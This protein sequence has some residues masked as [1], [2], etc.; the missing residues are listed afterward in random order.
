M[1]NE[2]CINYVMNGYYDTIPDRFI[3]NENEF[4][5]FA[6]FMCKRYNGIKQ[7][8]QESTPENEEREYDNYKAQEVKE[9]KELQE[10]PIMEQELPIMEQEVPKMEEEV[11]KMEVDNTLEENKKLERQQLLKQLEEADAREYGLQK[12]KSLQ[13]DEDEE[14]EIFQYM[15]NL[16][17][18]A[19]QEIDADAIEAEHNE[20]QQ[21]GDKQSDDKTLSV[22]E[23]VK[24]LLNNPIPET[25]I[26]TIEQYKIPLLIFNL[27][28]V[29]KYAI[30]N[31][32]MEIFKHVNKIGVN[33]PEEYKKMNKSVIVSLLKDISENINKYCPD[34]E[35]FLIQLETINEDVK[36]M[37]LIYDEIFEK[38]ENIDFFSYEFKGKL[39]DPKRS[40]IQE[41]MNL[42]E[43]SN[44]LSQGEVGLAKH[45]IT[46]RIEDILQLLETQDKSD[47][48]PKAAAAPKGSIEIPIVP[49]VFNIYKFF[50]NFLKYISYK[51]LLLNP[52]YDTIIQAISIFFT[53]A[54]FLMEEPGRKTLLS[55][56]YHRNRPQYKYFIEH[57]QNM[58]YYI[59][60]FSLVEFIG[61]QSDDMI[62]NSNSKTIQ[63]VI[64]YI[65]SNIV[66][67]GITSELFQRET[68][69]TI[70]ALQKYD[71]NIKKQFYKNKDF[72]DFQVS[73][74][75][76]LLLQLVEYMFPEEPNLSDKLFIDYSN[77]L[78]Q[79]KFPFLSIGNTDSIIIFDK[80]STKKYT[81]LNYVFAKCTPN[82]IINT[83]FVKMSY[84]L[85][86]D[87]EA[88]I[89][90]N[91]NNI[92]IDTFFTDV[93]NI[94]S[95][96]KPLI[97][98][99]KTKFFTYLLKFGNGVVEPSGKPFDAT[100][101][102]SMCYYNYYDTF[103][104]KL[105]NTT[106]TANAETI[107]LIDVL[108]LIMSILNNN[109]IIIIGW[110]G[111]WLSKIIEAFN[112]GNIQTKYN[113]LAELPKDYDWKFFVMPGGVF[114]TTI[115]EDR[116]FFFTFI[117]LIFRYLLTLL[118]QLYT[119]NTE[120]NVSREEITILIKDLQIIL[121]TQG[122]DEVSRQHGLPFPENLSAWTANLLILLQTRFGNFE[123]KIKL[124]PFD[125]VFFNYV[126]FA[127][128]YSHYL[129]I[130]IL[131]NPE[132]F[133]ILFD[134]IPILGTSSAESTI[135]IPS[136]YYYILNVRGFIIDI[137]MMVLDILQFTNRQ[138]KIKKDI[139]RYFE[140]LIV[141]LNEYLNKLENPQVDEAKLQIIS[142]IDIFLKE[143][144]VQN[145]DDLVN[146]NKQF[147]NPNDFIQ[148][149]KIYDI[150]K[151]EYNDADFVELRTKMKAL[152]SA[153]F[154][155]ETL[156]NLHTEVNKFDI[157][158]IIQC[159]GTTDGKNLN[160]QFSSL[161]PPFRFI[162]PDLTQKPN[163]IPI[164]DTCKQ[165]ISII[166][167]NYNEICSIIKNGDETISIENKQTLENLIKEIYQSD[168]F[169]QQQLLTDISS[170][171]SL[172]LMNKKNQRNIE[173]FFN[174]NIQDLIEE[175]Y[176]GS[177]TRQTRKNKRLL[178]K[179][180]KTRKPKRENKKRTKKNI[181][182]KKHN[183]KKTKNK[184][185]K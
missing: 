144:Y 168:I 70:I 11:N 50:Y 4:Y 171:V 100:E 72:I 74:L 129:D 161:A 175:V 155:F 182:S 65:Q 163:L 16:Y 124:D 151:R 88:I 148:T 57:F 49:R 106:A 34:F 45:G 66:K 59:Q 37:M 156:L 82:L 62:N 63:I 160:Q 94:F 53:E 141:Y 114:D 184:N 176:G 120:L 99:I 110:G 103:I 60:R 118:T 42:E 164:N 47:T 137:T 46:T 48:S 83:D 117:L 10:L 135:E 121:T 44:V 130:D 51:I 36:Y 9:V 166:F 77:A 25:F 159:N 15:Q 102:E 139:F 96:Y 6:V 136:Q 154:N 116:P 71:E 39:T 181:I 18:I 33:D 101:F 173:H 126:D 153:I 133:Y 169:K 150:F 69:D 32:K 85:L 119:G 78:T 40:K 142:Q 21:S 180:V 5:N 140:S 167:K 54:N 174:D 17:F 24:G 158:Y 104:N 73:N 43:V 2:E 125:V 68:G 89:E 170:V 93:E 86:T 138:P 183:N 67:L 80:N 185:K 134:K 98:S 95:F 97:K 108:S 29:L 172:A 7:K 23:I 1:A 128:K 13:E 58:C 87:D 31:V 146:N 113:L 178:N 61:E 76:F 28:Q 127:E 112:S 105:P 20:N 91:I 109:G 149:D 30:L 27:K 147:N 145:Y 90:K 35:E 56:L 26:E 84:Y 132:Y 165:I 92:E 3:N 177:K 157:S 38:K 75:Y 8:I 115:T 111:A 81:F 52:D 162:I 107:T 12:G 123:N 41:Q 64:E 19:E 122:Y 179:K 22:N 143:Y 55:L 152:C 131:D 14:A 79:P